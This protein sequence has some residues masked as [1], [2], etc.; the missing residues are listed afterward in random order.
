MRCDTKMAANIAAARRKAPVEE[1][2]P[3]RAEKQG[4]QGL[5]SDRLCPRSL[6][7]SIYGPWDF[8]NKRI[9]KAIYSVVHLN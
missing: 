3:W 7:A 4:K 1:R 6:L 2:A 8:T 9:N 5:V